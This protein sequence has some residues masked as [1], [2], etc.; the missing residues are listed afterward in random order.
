MQPWPS[1]L[2]FF[3]EAGQFVLISC[4]ARG[5]AMDWLS[6]PWPGGLPRFKGSSQHCLNRRLVCG[7]RSVWLGD[8]ALGDRQEDLPLGL[9]GQPH[10]LAPTIA[11]IHLTLLHA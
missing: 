9:R 4:C 8:L 2:Y 6:G 3:E 5:L 1:L 10:R 7:D 11:H